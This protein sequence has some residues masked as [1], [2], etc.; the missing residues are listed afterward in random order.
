MRKD[1][2]EN[3]LQVGMMFEDDVL[4]APQGGQLRA[5]MWT[6]TPTIMSKVSEAYM[7]N[8]F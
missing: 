8:V 3:I 7:S 5:N 4:L 2:H 6:K 1:Y